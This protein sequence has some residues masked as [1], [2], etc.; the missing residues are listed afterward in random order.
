MDF[1]EGKLYVYGDGRSGTLYKIMY[2]IWFFNAGDKWIKRWADPLSGQ[3]DN[4][5][6]HLRELSPVMAEMMEGTDD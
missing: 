3:T 1:E 6:V 5:T 2:G 4:F